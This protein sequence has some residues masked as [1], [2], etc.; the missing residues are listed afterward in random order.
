MCD[1]QLEVSIRRVRRHVYMAVEWL[2]AKIEGEPGLVSIRGKTPSERQ[3]VLFSEQDGPGMVYR[4]SV[5]GA[6][7][8]RRVHR[9]ATRAQGSQRILDEREAVVDRTEMLQTAG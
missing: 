3:Y 5:R 6:V 9:Y 1:P 8:F 7:E 4:P 2:I